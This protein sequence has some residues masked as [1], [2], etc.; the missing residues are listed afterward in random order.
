MINNLMPCRH[1]SRLVFDILLLTNI[2]TMI[3]SLYNPRPIPRLG[4]G[5]HL[6]CPRASTACQSQPGPHT[7][8]LIAHRLVCDSILSM[9]R[10]CAVEN[11]SVDPSIDERDVPLLGQ[12]RLSLYEDSTDDENNPPS[13]RERHMVDSNSDSDSSFD[14]SSLT[15]RQLARRY[16]CMRAPRIPL[17]VLLFPPW[18]MIAM[19][20][21]KMRY[22]TFFPWSEELLVIQNQYG[23]LKMSFHTMKH[24][25]SLQV[26]QAAHPLQILTTVRVVDKVPFLLNLLIFYISLCSTTKCGITGGTVV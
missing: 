12:R 23:F 4:L 10:R 18:N 9:R 3:N 8:R 22:V 1:A 15:Y 26:P 7:R 24:P 13:L 11:S 19:I 20:R 14:A 5:P 21:L 16:G 17:M 2:R 6:C 25:V